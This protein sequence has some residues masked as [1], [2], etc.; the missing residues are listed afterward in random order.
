[1]EDLK[2]RLLKIMNSEGLT[3]SAFADAIGVQRSGI[4]HILS[5]RNKPSLDFVQKILSCFPKY[6]AEWLVNGTGEVYKKPTQKSIFDEIPNNQTEKVALNKSN[7]NDS[8]IKE[9][10]DISIKNDE[11][12]PKNTDLASDNPVNQIK[13]PVIEDIKETESQIEQ[14]IV[15]YNDKSFKQYFPGK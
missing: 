7:Q 5:G 14:I 6:N 12:Q 4:S 3:P 1:M 2:T 13:A 10:V 15:F 11:S 9:P 8:T